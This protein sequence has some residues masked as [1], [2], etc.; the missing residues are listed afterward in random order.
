[1]LA[2]RTAT[3]LVNRRQR[4]KRR[5]RRLIAVIALGPVLFFILVLIVFA[6]GGNDPNLVPSTTAVSDI[7]PE[8]LALYQ[9]AA[10]AQQIDWTILAGI[11]KV[12]CDHGRSQLAGCASIRAGVRRTGRRHDDQVRG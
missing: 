7:P 1:M 5:R 2:F 3:G 11:G 6:A 10:Q 12:E 4:D 9:E 8:F